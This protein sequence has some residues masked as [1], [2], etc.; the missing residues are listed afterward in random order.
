MKKLLKVVAGVALA[1]CMLLPL[2]AC[3]DTN[4]N[5]EEIK[6][7]Q[8]QIQDLQNEINSSKNDNVT[9][10]G[11]PKFEYSLNEPIPYYINGTK[12]FD[13]TITSFYHNQSNITVFEYNVNFIPSFNA[14]P[15]EVFSA[16]IYNVPENTFATP[17]TINDDGMGFSNNLSINQKNIILFYYGSPFVCITATPTRT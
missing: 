13:F 10:T 3:S 15:S 14:K 7:L 16:V 11:C 9:L 6:Q 8:Q 12:I 2:A 17:Y 5:S 4:G 1:G